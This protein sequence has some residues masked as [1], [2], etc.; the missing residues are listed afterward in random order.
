MSLRRKFG[1][2]FYVVGV[3]LLFNIRTREFYGILCLYVALD[4]FK[5]DER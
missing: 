4:L 1:Y 3:I 5:K 2:L